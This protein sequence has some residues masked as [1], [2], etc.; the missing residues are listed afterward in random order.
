MF[1]P[2]ISLL[3]LC[4]PL[5]TTA[6]LSG[7]VQSPGYPRGYPN[8]ANAT[9]KRCAP[10]GHTLSL[11]LTHLDLEDSEDCNSDIL[12]ISSDEGT[13][14]SLCG[15]KSYKELQSSVNPLLQSSVSGCLM[16]SF[17]SDF[18]NLKRHSGY[19]AFYTVQDVDECANP[20]NSCTQFCS[21]Y[22]GGYRCFCRLGYFLEEDQHT[23][24]V[25]CS[26]DLSGSQT[27]TVTSPDYPN[28]YAEHAHCS[29]T[30]AVDQS[31]QLVLE[32]AGEFDIEQG[33]KGQCTDTLMIKTPSKEFGP[34]CGNAPPPSPLLTE[35]HQ[36]KILFNSDGTGL[37]T[38][39][40]LT[41]RT[42]GKTCPGVVTPHSSL[43]P[44]KPEYLQGDQVIVRC[45]LGYVID[46]IKLGNGILNDKEYK[47]VCQ[48]TGSWSSVFPC[49]PVD[50]GPPDIPDD[51]PLQLLDEIPGT[52]YQDE[53]Q[54]KCESTYYTLE[55]NE[56]YVCSAEG[57]WTSKSG[58]TTLPRCEAVCGKAEDGIH[59]V[60]RILGGAIAQLGQ[61]PW[62]LLLKKD[63]ALKGGASLI[64]DRVLVLL[65]VDVENTE[66][67]LLSKTACDDDILSLYQ[68]LIGSANMRRLCHGAT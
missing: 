38:G 32:F 5:S 28:A 22:I 20:D 62:Q 55:P 18:S 67:G 41:Y 56:S 39:F 14:V 58:N 68:L 35:S 29:Y 59:S 65:S 10:D 25:N 16:L 47:S 42:T 27:G 12:E 17:T 1:L 19:R 15:Q 48:P 26:K 34:F 66:R 57:Y 49:G 30:L 21:N 4:L 33:E 64:N 8:E 45:D 23:C 63:G 24:T 11:T 31:L 7:W 40:K 53:V 52:Q 2:V 13:L 51:G 54:F 3:I 6:P 36:A 46:T 37:N 43:N 60:S 50:C 44:Q 9:W 61:I